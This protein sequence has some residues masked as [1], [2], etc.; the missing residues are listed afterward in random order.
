MT[1]EEVAALQARYGAEAQAPVEKDI[2]TYIELGR[3]HYGTQKFD[4][5]AETVVK[6][7]GD[8]KDV[9]RAALAGFNAPHA[10]VMHLADNEARLQA[11]SKMRP[12]EIVVE[13]AR[14]ESQMSPHHVGYGAEPAYRREAKSGRVS[15]E[16]W[17]HTGGANIKDDAEWNRQ[18]DKHM[19]E[20]SKHRN[21]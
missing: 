21:R 19:A 18:F 13:L 7:L 16:E 15:A 9:F 6:A 3:S 1:P 11:M 2:S 14:I 20:R 5:A 12:E 4:E 8:R 17:R 10:A